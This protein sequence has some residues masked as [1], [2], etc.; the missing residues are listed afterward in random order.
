MLLLMSLSLVEMTALNN[1]QI[2]ARHHSNCKLSITSILVWSA[3][4]FWMNHNT[5]KNKNNN[6][7]NDSQ[8]STNQINTNR[9]DDDDM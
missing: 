5:E 7:N 9:Y 8:T 1:L 4:G 2:V 3:Y 6:N